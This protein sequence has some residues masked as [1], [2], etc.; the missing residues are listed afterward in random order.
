MSHRS[1]LPVP[2]L[3]LAGLC[4]IHAQVPELNWPVEVVSSGHGF[5]EGAAL[6]P[7]G[8]VFFSDMDHDQILRF[9]PV[10]G[11]TEVWQPESGK[12]NGLFILEGKLYGCEAAG[13]SLV[14]YD[15]E[16]GPSSRKV[17]A[18]T[19]QGDS[20]GCPND[21]TIIGNKLYFSEFWIDGFQQW[22]GAEREIF[23]NRVYVLSLDGQRLDTLEFD[24]ETPNGVASSPDRSTLFVAD[25]E[26]DKLYKSLVIN[27]RAGP[28]ELLCDLE[29]LGLHGPDGMAIAPDGRIFLALYGSDKLL[30]L[31]PDGSAVGTLSTGPLTSN[32]IFAS[33]G[34]TLYITA[35]QK[36]KKVIV[37]KS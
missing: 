4:T 33:D 28:P 14:Q 13:R 16:A 26:A 35:D 11:R 9:D 12:T 24:F 29:K 15:L 34:R 23:E 18:A 31:A 19:Y 30:V 2:A 10:P 21:L 37:P 17:L 8:T 22:S 7:D 32:C 25:Y 3:I 20:L 36:L 1:H 5:T 6:A 27:D